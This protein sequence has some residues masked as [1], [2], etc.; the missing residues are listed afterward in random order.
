V[1]A[2]RLPA[3]IEAPTALSAFAHDIMPAPRSWAEAFVNVAEFTEH[4]SGGH[5][6]PGNDRRT[7]RTTFVMP[8]G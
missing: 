8:R 3:R 1:Q 5:L 6:R 7:T 2:A 4:E